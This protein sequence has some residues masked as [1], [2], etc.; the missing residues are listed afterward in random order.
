VLEPWDAISFPPD[1]WRR[2]EN[3]SAANAWGFAVLD[4]HEH[5][6][7]PDP[8]WPGWIV[9]AAEQH[10][11]RT[12]AQGRMVKPENF[13]ELEADVRARIDS[14]GSIGAPAPQAGA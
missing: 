2:L 4:P 1:L 14:T 8:R 13:A 6:R 7:G 12:D 9:D 10:G 3:V 11:V 5:F